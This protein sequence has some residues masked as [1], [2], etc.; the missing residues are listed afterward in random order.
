MK[1]LWKKEINTKCWKEKE[2]ISKQQGN[3]FCFWILCHILN[4]WY[5]RHSEEARYATIENNDQIL[6]A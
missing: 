4:K 1:K 6:V 5:V 2:G 3:T